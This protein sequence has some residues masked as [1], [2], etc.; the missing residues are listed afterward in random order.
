MDLSA[1][2]FAVPPPEV[3]F[4]HQAVHQTYGAMVKNL[5]AFSQ[6]PDFDVA[7]FR[8]SFDRQHCLML[9]RSQAGRMRGLLAETEKLAQG[10]P[11]LGQHDVVFFGNF[12][13][14]HKGC[15]DNISRDAPNSNLICPIAQSP[16]QSNRPFKLLDLYRTAM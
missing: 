8:K 2:R 12:V 5:K 11:E 7:P 10:V 6:F 15:A 3:F 13:R 14:G 16:A 9:L 4:R 1:V